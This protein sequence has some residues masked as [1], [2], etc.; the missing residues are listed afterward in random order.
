MKRKKSTKAARMALY[1]QEKG[2]MMNI[3]QYIFVLYLLN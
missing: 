2:V 3:E 1:M